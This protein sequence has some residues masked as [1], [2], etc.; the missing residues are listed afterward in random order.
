MIFHGAVD[1]MG[2]VPFLDMEQCWTTAI[3]RFFNVAINSKSTAFFLSL[4]TCLHVTH[5][6]HENPAYTKFETSAVLG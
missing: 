5:R 6:D 3:V 4:L 2:L 1:L